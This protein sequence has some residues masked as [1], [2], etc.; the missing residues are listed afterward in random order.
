MR[1]ILINIARLGVKEL[2]TL[3]HELMLVLLIIGSF[4]AAIYSAAT[5]TSQELNNAPIGIVDLDQSTLTR[6]IVSAFY[7]P[8]FKRPDHL[9]STEADRG[10]DAGRYTFVIEFPPGFERDFKRGQTPAV[11]VNI[12]AT[13]MTQAFIGAGYIQNIIQGEVKD[14]LRSAQPDQISPIELVTRVKFNPNLTSTWF[15]AVMELINNITMLS[16]ILTGAAL[17][18]EREHGTLEHLLV[19]PITPAEIV[20]S[21]IWSMAVVVLG[22]AWLSLELV[23]KGALGVPITGSITLF[24]LGAL[25]HLMATTSIGIFLGTV[26]RSMPQF[27]LLIILV[28]IPLE[29]L[30]G[31]ITPRES[32]PELIQNLMLAAPTTHFVSLAQAILFRGADFDTVWLRFLALMLIAGIFFGASLALFRRRI[33]SA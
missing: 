32:M 5:A 26:S 19:M 13:R 29:M 14:F 30:S 6:K 9:T 1:Q 23:L 27:G 7:G 18:R 25:L 21:K 22:A 3:T 33:A 15:G 20:L 31:G 11:E 4:S 8:M 12:D 24:M 16:I 17:I 10:L 2:R 28:I